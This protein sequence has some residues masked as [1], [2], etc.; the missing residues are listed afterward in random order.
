M[1][2]KLLESEQRAVILSVLSTEDLRQ[3]FGVGAVFLDDK[4]REE[5]VI[6]RLLEL[7]RSGYS[8]VD[9]YV[10]YNCIC[11]ILEKDGEFWS[12]V[13]GMVVGTIAEDAVIRRILK[14]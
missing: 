12:S 14:T 6:Q 8:L 7:E 1:N 11:A 2:E 9:F 4:E 3:V 5:E 10:K 13:D